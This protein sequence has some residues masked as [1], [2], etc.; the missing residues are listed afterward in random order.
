MA[1]TDTDLRRLARLARLRLEETEISGL[2]EQ[3]AG[4]LGLIDQLQAVD[5]RGIEPLSHAL[6]LEA[7]LREDVVTETDQRARFQSV[8]PQVEEGLYLVPKVIE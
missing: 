4:I 2:R 6:D 3:F 5:T 8:A 7:R 1:L